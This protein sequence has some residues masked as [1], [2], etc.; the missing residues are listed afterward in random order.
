MKTESFAKER[1]LPL[2]FGAA[3]LGA[4]AIVVQHFSAEEEFARLAHQTNPVWLLA[5]L[6]LQ[7]ITYL[8]QGE[9]WRNAGKS[10]GSTLS[11]W[12][13]YKL[14]LIKLFVD[15]ALPSAGFSGTIVV[16]RLLGHHAL[17]RPVVSAILVISTTSFFFAYVVSL[18]GALMFLFFTG[19]NAALIIVPSIL[20]MVSGVALSVAMIGLSG[21]NLVQHLGRFGRFAVVQNALSAMREADGE[22]VRNIQIQVRAALYQALTFLLDGVTLWMLLRSL[23][24]AA[25]PAHAFASFMIANLVRTIGIVPGGLGTF[26]ATA[27]LMLKM[28]GISVAAALSATVLFRLVT[29]VLP[30][31]PGLWFSRHLLRQ[32]HPR[33]V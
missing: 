26:E 13:V 25:S 4:V 32:H 30:M 20:F 28:D 3:C 5:A 9:I 16:A 11:I 24:V 27:V 15:Q 12:T 19:R 21:R 18:T 6:G 7:A 29:F 10:S 23:G 1:W 22:L 17:R 31:A 33:P 14:A 2:L 8:A